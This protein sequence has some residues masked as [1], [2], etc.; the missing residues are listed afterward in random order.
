MLAVCF[1]GPAAWLGKGDPFALFLR[2]LGAVA[3]I[4]PDRKLRWP[5]MG[6]VNLPT[7]P[8]SGVL[9]VLFTLSSISFD[10]L[11]YTF[12][13][14]A[15]VGENPL[16]YPG[17]TAMMGA[18]TLGLVLTFAA[19]GLVF[20]GCVFLGWVL[21]GRPG[22]AAAHFGRFVYVLIPISI[23]FHFAHYLSAMEVNL[24]YLAIALNDP[25]GLGANWLGL[26][27]YEVTTSFLNTASGALATFRAQTIAIVLGHGIG[28]AAAH[29]TAVRANLPRSRTL[30]LEAP[31]AVFMTLYTSFS[32]WLLATPAIS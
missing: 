10:G 32:L 7:L 25:F 11:M 27:K 22:E 13:W 5:G 3:P 19:L 29:A 20:Y 31:L 8:T 14:L 23:A 1:F 6:L 16:N 26:D 18:N 12:L 9:F 17:R 21:A 2:Q 30:L 15:S 24:Q 28:V 4:G